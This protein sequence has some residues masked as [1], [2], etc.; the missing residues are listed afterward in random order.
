MRIRPNET[1]LNASLSS[2]SID[3]LGIRTL[4]GSDHIQHCHVGRALQS[5]FSGVHEV[6]VFLS[7]KIETCPLWSSDMVEFVPISV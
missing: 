2:I 1:F 5:L 3:R 7:A 4:E 6:A